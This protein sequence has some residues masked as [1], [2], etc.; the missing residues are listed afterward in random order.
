MKR[1]SRRYNDKDSAWYW[2]RGDKVQVTEGKYIGKTGQLEKVIHPSH[3][4]Q[5]LL[6]YMKL[7]RPFA[8]ASKSGAVTHLW[9]P[10]DA[11]KN[12][13]LERADKIKEI[14]KNEK[15]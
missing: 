15:I 1:G 13:T 12:V 6:V 10:S 8:S 3:L 7:S 2:N 4:G 9:F 14:I 5:Q 11:L